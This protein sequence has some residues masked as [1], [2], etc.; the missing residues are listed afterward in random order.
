MCRADLMVDALDE[1][2]EVSIQQEW[3]TSD[4]PVWMYMAHRGKIGYIPESTAVY[5]KSTDSISNTKSHH[6]RK[7]FI[8]SDLDIKNYFIEK[9]NP[10]E[11]VVRQARGAIACDL[12]KYTLRHRLPQKKIYRTMVLKD[13]ESIPNKKI[14][15]Y[16]KH[17]WLEPLYF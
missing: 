15:F 5:T 9:Y 3:Q 16:A 4:Y 6:K 7:G 1:L 17:N 11:E 13:Q 2:V 10:A 8:T 14:I 12:Y